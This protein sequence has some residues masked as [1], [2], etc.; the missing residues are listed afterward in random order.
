VRSAVAT[1]AGLVLTFGGLT[2]AFAADAAPSSATPATASSGARATTV[3]TPTTETMTHWSCDRAARARVS[4]TWISQTQA[5][6]RWKAS[7]RGADGRTPVLRIVGLDHNGAEPA[8]KRN[9]FADDGKVIVRGGPGASRSDERAWTP[10]LTHLDEIEVWIWNGVGKRRDSCG[11]NVVKRLNDH[12]Y[13][14]ERTAPRSYADSKALRD[15]I[16]AKAWRQYRGVNHE[17][18]DNCS[19]YSRPF[20]APNICHAWCADFAWWLWAESGVRGAKAYNSSYTDDFAD[21]WRVTFKPLG[22]SRKPARGDVIVWS[23]RTDGINGHVGVVVAAKGWKVKV[24]H[25]NWG[26][27]V[28]F[29]GWIDPFTST[30]DYGNKHV[31]GF[32]SPA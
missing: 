24:I 5:R 12:R 13:S 10:N 29:M 32:A 27:R 7:D 3:P 6:I 4:V 23:H 19:R 11:F 18:F 9:F 25:G 30:Q 22:G 21:E 15:R 20:Y 17:S 14:P 2:P 28:S 26:D 31:I 1:L 8:V 16:V